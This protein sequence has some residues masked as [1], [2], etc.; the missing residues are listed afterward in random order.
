MQPTALFPFVHLINQKRE[1]S[2]QPAGFSLLPLRGDFL[3]PLSALS[4][5][6]AA[7]G[8]PL[9]PAAGDTGPGQAR[10]LHSAQQ[11]GHPGSMRVAPASCQADKTT[12]SV[13]V[14]GCWGRKEAQAQEGAGMGRVPARW[15][16]DRGP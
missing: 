5:R 2:P 14:H 7:A 1:P 6:F 9:T 3:F 12:I 4:F 11:S 16:I 13:S 15:G 10:P 8:P